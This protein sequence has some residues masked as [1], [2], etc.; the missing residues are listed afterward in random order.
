MPVTRPFRSRLAVG[1][2]L[3]QFSPDPA[4]RRHERLRRPAAPLGGRANL[5]WFGRNRSLSEDFEN[6]TATLGIFTTVASIQLALRRQVV[7]PG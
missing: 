2:Y 4:E 3:D 7:M 6:L 1:A 5:S